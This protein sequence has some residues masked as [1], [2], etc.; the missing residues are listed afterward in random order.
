MEGITGG[1]NVALTVNVDWG[2]EYLP[3]MLEILEE[4]QARVTFFVTGVWAEKNAG[5]V[6]QMAAAGHSVQSHGY[7]HDH[8]NQLSPQD[9]AAELNKAEQSIAGI[10]GRP[11]VAFASPYGEFDDNVAIASARAGYRLIM[12]T[13]DTIDWEKPAPDVITKRVLSK[14]QN[15][16]IVLMHPT[17]NTLAALPEILTGIR[18]KGYQCLTIEEILCM[19]PAKDETLR[20]AAETREINC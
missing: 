7:R 18:E 13:I 5:L 15:D 16:A 1:P 12:W 9:I 17:E 20:E 19:G 3:G 10:T 14:L 2:E 6:R 4:K 8:Y 11:C